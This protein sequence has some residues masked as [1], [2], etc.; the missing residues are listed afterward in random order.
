[1]SVALVCV[2]A[3]RVKTPLLILL[4]DADK[5]VPPPQSYDY[6]RLLRARGVR[7]RCLNY[8]GAGHGLVDVAADVWVNSAL[9]LQG[10][11]LL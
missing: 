11:Y 6:F 2:R 10:V 4:G 3:R 5:R 7:S 9:W 1:M 8:P